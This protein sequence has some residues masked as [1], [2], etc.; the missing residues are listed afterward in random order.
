MDSEQVIFI[1]T[2]FWPYNY[3]LRP[4]DFQKLGFFLQ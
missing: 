3:D 2:E 4:Y 1:F